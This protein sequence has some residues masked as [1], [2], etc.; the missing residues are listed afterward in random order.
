M[1]HLTLSLLGT[2]EARLDDLLLTGFRSDKVRALLAYLAVEADRPHRRARLAGLFWPEWNEAEAR[3]YLRQSLANLQT[4]LANESPPVLLVTRETMQLH[5]AMMEVVDVLAFERNVALPANLM[6]QPSTVAALQAAV[7]LY[8]GPFLEGFFLNGCPEFEAWVVLTRTR[9]QQKILAALAWLADYFQRQHEYEPAFSYARRRVELE[10]TTEE[11]Q[12]QLIRLLALAGQRSAALTQFDLCCALLR[13][14]VGVEPSAETVAL[15]QQIL[16]GEVTALRQGSLLAPLVT[17]AALPATPQQPAFMNSPTSDHRTPV[18]VARHA[19][20]AHLERMMAAAHAGQGAVA[21]VTGDAGY[22]KTALLHDFA[23]HAQQRFPDLVVASGNCNAHTGIGDPYLPFCEILTMLLGEVEARWAAGVLSSAAALRL[24]QLTPLALQTLV[25]QAPDLIDTFVAAG[26]VLERAAA[27]AATE[28]HLTQLQERIITRHTTKSGTQP[29]QDELFAQ[30]TAFLQRV[31]QQHPLLLIL[32]DLQWADVGSINLLFH[33]GRQIAGSRLLLV[34]AY[35][36]TDVKLGRA[37]GA[38]WARH[39]LEPVVNELKRTY[40]NV[41]VDLW[42][43]DGQAFVDAFVDTEPNR[44]DDGFRQM[45]YAQTE[46]HPLF[47]VEL[48]RGMQERGD[49]VRNDDGYWQSGATLDWETLPARVEAV[50][51]ERIRRLPPDLQQLLTVASV[52]GEFFT[53]EVLSALL[54]ANHAEVMRWLSDELER[55]HRLVRAQGVERLRQQRFARYRF[56]HIL[57]QRYLHQQLDPVERAY[58]HEAVGHALEA[59]Y[60]QQAADLALIASPLARH[61][62]EAG[63]LER[64]IPYLRMAGNR[65]LRLSANEEAITHLTQARTLLQSLPENEARNRMELDLCLLVGPALIAN[66]GYASPQVLE[67]YTTARR[68]GQMVGT[69]AQQLQTLWGL[70]SYYY[71]GGCYRQALHLSHEFMGVVESNQSV[72]LLAEAHRS[73]GAVFWNLGQLAQARYHLEQAIALYDAAQH[74]EIVHLYGQDTGVGAYDFL[75]LTQWLLG[76]PE[77]AHHSTL[78]GVALAEQLAHPFSLAYALCNVVM[79]SQIWRDLR[80][81]QEYLVATLTLSTKHGFTF[82]SSIAVTVQGWLL[83]QR[84]QTAEGLVELQR[85]LALAKS[86]KSRWFRPYFLSLLADG[87]RMTGAIEA[88]LQVLQELLADQ[89]NE[90]LQWQAEIYRLQ[91]E[92]WLQ[93]NQQEYP[94]AEQMAVDCFQQALHIARQQSAKSLELRAAMSLAR[95]WHATGKSAAAYEL[96]AP[97]YGWFT[98]GFDTADL[99]EA[100]ALLDNLSTTITER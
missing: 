4:L 56:G 58:W 73:L 18:I 46:G 75:A 86:I 88:G 67:T 84:Q 31:A 40:G 91:G 99:Q 63:L 5:P 2:I 55:R 34:G 39:P 94:A 44:F 11:A 27:M 97:V 65:A 60:H 10:P 9:L 25:E 15:Y 1:S 69:V 29:R 57:F 35:R 59:L 51:S 90:D 28:P 7:A 42:Q 16:R 89:E 53:V 72:H 95:F 92:L 64:A 12:Q 36:P 93:C 71:V 48:L 70:R 49:L 68:L 78:A 37:T 98:E 50:I 61:F 23:R 83:I 76:Y 17:L 47:T 33:L 45:L 13:Q 21:F 100:K 77:Q 8:R 66:R 80:L 74:N 3:T 38:H 32:D 26:L 19:E 54:P 96:L 85:G 30:Y 82:W 52:E 62:V 24:W 14:E 6:P 20:L 43:A 41:E 81:L 22:G 79:L 87:Y